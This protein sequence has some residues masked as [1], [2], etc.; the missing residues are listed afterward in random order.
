MPSLSSSYKCSRNNLAAS[1]RIK[2]VGTMSY[3]WDL[4]LLSLSFFFTF[5]LMMILFRSNVYKNKVC[6]KYLVNLMRMKVKVGKKYAIYLPK[7]IV[8]ELDIRE[9]DYILLT[10]RRGEIL[11]KP[12]KRAVPIKP[13]ATITFE[14]VEE[15]GEELSKRIL[16]E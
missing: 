15:V 9:G 12:I 10:V 16:G 7:S 3:S 11:L 1:R 13:W 4:T 8:E 6:L 5:Y 2:R 14:E